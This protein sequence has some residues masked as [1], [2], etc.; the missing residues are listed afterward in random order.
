MRTAQLWMR[1]PAI[2]ECVAALG[3]ARKNLGNSGLFLIKS[4]LIKSFLQ[5]V[6]K[7]CCQCT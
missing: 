4:F 6:M 1:D 5:R 3:M 7:V 2:C